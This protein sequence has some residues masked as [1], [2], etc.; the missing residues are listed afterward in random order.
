METKMEDWSDEKKALID[1][2]KPY[3]SDENDLLLRDADLSLRRNRDV[4]FAAV[5]V[6]G[7]N[8]QHF[9][10]SLKKDLEIVM[11]AVEGDGYLF[12]GLGLEY[13]DESL[14][15]DKDVVLAAVCNFPG[16]LE[17]ADESLRK[18]RE[19]VLTAVGSVPGSIKYAD[20]SLRNDRDFVLELAVKNSGVLELLDKS[21]RD[22]KDFLREVAEL[23]RELS[24]MNYFK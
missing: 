4:A 20:D 15:K 1:A 9:D 10:D 17:F 3:Q 5:K 18:D 21:F 7:G 6:W 19:V 12:D 24:Q 23:R 11:A 22:D 8:L 14:R 13:A 2:M 16:A